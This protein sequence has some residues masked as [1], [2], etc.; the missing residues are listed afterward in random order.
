[1]SKVL[2]VGDVA[3]T[4]AVTV[5]V[6]VVSAGALTVTVKLKVA[7]FPEASVAVQVTVVLPIGNSEPEV[8]EHGMNQLAPILFPPSSKSFAKML[9]ETL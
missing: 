3:L 2:P 1:M 8:G 7:E 6:E 4:Y 9:N 5:I